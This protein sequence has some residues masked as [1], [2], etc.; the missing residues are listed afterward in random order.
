MRSYQTTTFRFRKHWLAWAAGAALTP[1]PLWALELVQA[2][3][4]TVQ[5]YV[6]PNVIISIDDSGS[7]NY[8]LD[9]ENATNASN[10]TEPDLAGGKWSSNSRRMNV[11]KYALKGIFDPNDPNYDNTLL[12][13][14]KIRLAWQSM[15]GNNSTPNTLNS[16]STAAVAQTNS[17]KVLDS[18]HRTNF[19]SFITKL[20]PSSSTPSHSM[21]KNADEYMR[22]PPNEY[23]P[24]ASKPGTKGA[25]YLGCRRNYHIFMT[26]GRWNGTTSG[27]SQDDNTKNTYVPM[28]G[29]TAGTAFGS[30]SA[31]SITR[32]KTQ[33][34]ADT[35][36]NTLA[37]WTFYSWAKP[38]RTDLSGKPEP[39][40]DYRKAPQTEDFGKDANNKTATLDRFWNP[41]YNPADWPHMVTYTIGF[42]AMAH[43]WPGFSSPQNPSASNPCVRG[44]NSICA[45]ST[46]VPFGYDGSFPDLVTGAVKWP[47]LDN[48]NKRSLDLWHAA[49][50]G[51]GRFYAVEK[52]EDLEKAFREIFQQ[53]NTQTDPD[54]T[55]TATSG[56]NTSRNDVGKYTGAYEP[57]NAWKGYVMAETVKKDGTTE[58]AAGWSGKNTAYKLDDSSFSVADR[59]VLS[60][61]DEWTT[62]KYKGGVSFQWNDN[63]TYLSTGQKYW[64]GLNTNSTAPAVT[65]KT[66]GKNVLDFIRGERGKE[67]SEITG[68]TATKPFRERLSRQ[69][70]IINSVVWYTG[71][72]VSGY[73]LKGYSAF[74]R[75]LKNRLP[76]IYV[77]GNDGMLHGFSAQDGTEKIAYVPRGV[78][79]NLSLLTDPTYNN[80]HRFFVDGS[81][82]TGD[83]DMG[84]GVQDPDDPDYTPSYTPD[85][86]T[87]LVGTL[88]AG[89]KGYF[90]LDVT[91]P[92]S[93]T[94]VTGP[95]FEPGQAGSL[96]VMDRTRSN[97]GNVSAPI[98]S[99]LPNTAPA[100]A[101]TTCEE[102]SKALPTCNRT[103]ISTAEKA[104]CTNETTEDRDIGNI[105]ARPVIDE[106]NAMRTTQITRMNNNRWAVV[107]GN[108]YNSANQRPVLLIQYLDGNKELLRIPTVGTVTS[109][110]TPGTG[111]A[112]DN[113]LMHPRLVD[114]NGDDRP[115]VAYA[116]DNLGNLWKFD[117][118][119]VSDAEWKVAFGGTPLFTAKGPKTLSATTRGEIQPITIAST[120]RE[121]D[122]KKTVGSG[123]N[124]KEVDVG[125]MMVIFGTGRNV[126]DRV[127][128]GEAPNEVVLYAGDENN[129]NVQTLYSVLD[130]TRY[131]TVSTSKGKRLEVHPGGGTCTPIPGPDCAPTPTALGEGV[132]NA[133]LVKRTVDELSG[134]AAGKINAADTIDWKENNGWYMDYPAVGERQLKPIEFYD[135]SNILAVYS[136]VPA[137]GSNVNP[138]VETCT[139][140]TVDEERQY[141]TFINAMDGAA[142]SIQLVDFNGDGAFDSTA[143]QNVSRVAVAKGAHNLINNGGQNEDIDVKNNREKLARMPEQSLRATWR[144]LK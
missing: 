75:A 1:T 73:P 77:G 45:P 31:T 44:A 79:P 68:Y 46:M 9:Q 105:T 128:T 67:G 129:T 87:L 103:G 10:R 17:M 106:T 96:V 142:P 12:P 134:G 5:P 47:L 88:G 14:S 101:R 118:T 136:Q 117:L 127:V 92:S 139:A 35:Y 107:M 83:V 38:L 11:L 61:S 110:P 78:I 54:M 6:T 23:G 98:C 34:Y 141:R 89:G 102:L 122:R 63:Q 48:E 85:W 72:P 19:I 59:L 39:S 8:R 55:S 143:D 21:F 57:K 28:D 109:P 119:N 144:Q 124:I 51:R 126:A 56:S 137:K 25:P 16:S 24:W 90:V 82:M 93:S 113:G 108:G 58:P 114:I 76:M 125:G 22:L 36:S 97:T 4:G 52:G 84:S 133:K 66:N 30:T 86:R 13:D 104:A 100:N 95:A 131:R 81:P 65:D 120:V 50:N 20:S 94:S 135:G 74:T 132:A 62:S 121:N 3:P 49:L 130:N 37:D 112:N 7:M 70:D 138:N 33:L 69:G 91:N 40:A 60:W 115:D 116:G 42:S 99:T 41:K 15:N 27:G 80:K 26:D 53:I 71:A 123:T 2:P 32:S 140:T 43:T 111:L 18:S 64:L 29:T